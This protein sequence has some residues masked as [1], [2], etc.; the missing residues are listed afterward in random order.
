M[1]LIPD[2]HLPAW[3]KDTAAAARAAFAAMTDD[4]V[5]AE[6][7]RLAGNHEGFHWTQAAFGEAA[8]RMG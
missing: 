1:T 6:L 3:S 5:H 8:R 7:L 2:K 4:E